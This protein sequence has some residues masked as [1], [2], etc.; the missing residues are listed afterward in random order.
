MTLRARLSA[1]AFCAAMAGVAT[2][3]RADTLQEVVSRG[4]LRVGT[5]GDY[6]PY[7]E[8]DAATGAWRGSDVELARSLAAN[9][10]VSLEF[11]PT[12][13][14][15]LAEDAVARRFDIAVGGI[16]I[17]PERE[18][19]AFFSTPHAQDGKT[20]LAPC[21][22]LASLDE[23]RELNRP[24]VRIIVN[25][26]G[27]NEAFA[28]RQL[29]QAMLTVHRDNLSVF[30]ELIEGRADAM[31]TDAVEAQL[32]SRLHPGVLCAAHPQKPFDHAD[33]A[34]LLPK[35][36]A[37]KRTV[38]DWLRPLLKRGDV[39][40]V[41]ARWL[42]SPT[43]R[44]VPLL[45]LIDARLA[46][47]ADVARYKWNTGGSIEDPARERDLLAALTR[48]GESQGVPAQRT[49]MFF[50]AQFAAARQL[51]QDLFV[52]WR[53]QKRERLPPAPDLARQ[54]RPA[55][56]A[57]SADMVRALASADLTEQA[58]KAREGVLS[59]QLLSPSAARIALAPLAGLAN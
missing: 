14:A 30:D 51:Q 35:D 26:G 2:P 25:P 45:D 7:A 16:S 52:L 41:Q 59:E 23:L 1:L 8:H 57:I 24:T 38:D 54:I 4:L 40:A 36:S 12:T 48:Q 39:A 33:K 50:E 32:Q 47:M 53:S 49:A 27:T 55:L 31:I 56:D 13:W 5:P 44:P 34:L 43:L 22:K 37:F 10:G 15:R 46:V 11:V 29:P 42:A 58:A 28:R 9:L 17:T 6:R 21:A 3:S 20:A 19:L 18:R